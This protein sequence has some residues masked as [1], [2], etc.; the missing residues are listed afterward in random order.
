MKE[1]TLNL[2]KFSSQEPI[3]LIGMRA[4]GKTTFGLNLAKALNFSFMDM[5]DIINERIRSIE[6]FANIKEAVKAKGKE[7]T[8][9]VFYIL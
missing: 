9:D 4:S 5:D 3:F 2:A 6:G 8:F 7:N 1:L